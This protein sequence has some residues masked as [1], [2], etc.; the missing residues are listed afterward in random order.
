MV[1]TCRANTRSRVE[2]LYRKGFSFRK[3]NTQDSDYNTKALYGRVTG[4]CYV[5]T[6]RVVHKSVLR[7]IILST[8]YDTDVHAT[9]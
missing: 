2:S 7:M 4:L 5:G 9:V 1:G 8:G 3:R 6:A